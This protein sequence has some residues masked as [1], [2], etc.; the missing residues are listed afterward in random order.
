MNTTKKI[1]NAIIGYAGSSEDVNKMSMRFMGIVTA[2]IA[3]FA[4]SVLLCLGIFIDLPTGTTPEQLVA[5]W[6][7]IIQALV[8]MTAATLYLVGMFRA[9]KKALETKDIG[10]L[11]GYK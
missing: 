2:V 1:I 6:G 9:V 3:K 5:A 11:C 8:Y 10:A 4:P 7:P